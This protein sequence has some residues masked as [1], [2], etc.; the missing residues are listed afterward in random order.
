MT[1]GLTDQIQ[2]NGMQSGLLEEDVQLV[3]L[4]SPMTDAEGEDTILVHE[5]QSME[6]RGLN[7]LEQRSFRFTVPEGADGF[8]VNISVHFR[9][10]PPYFLRELGLEGL[11]DRLEVFTIASTHLILDP[12]P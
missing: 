3:N 8:P 9:N 10:L 11:V 1:S 6:L 2:A 5:A 4:Q 7:H 12:A